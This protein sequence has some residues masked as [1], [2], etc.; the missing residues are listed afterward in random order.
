MTFLLPKDYHS[1]FEFSIGLKEKDIPHYFS[2]QYQKHNSSNSN[3]VRNLKDLFS[4]LENRFQFLIQHYNERY[5]NEYSRIKENEVENKVKK[6]SNWD[7]ESFWY[8]EGVIERPF[9][10]AWHQKQHKRITIKKFNE[11]KSGFEDF[12]E[13][14]VKDDEIEDFQK[15]I[16]SKKI[17][18]KGKPSQL[19]FLILE[20]VGKGWIELPTNSYKK[21]AKYLMELFDVETTHN[22]LENEINP[23]KNSLELD[24]QR[25]VTIKNRKE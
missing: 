17:K 23:N 25:F 7:D 8:F 9:P 24:N 6:I 10:I 16:L 12:I 11:I 20:L 3:F 2:N 21:S 5:L 15:N 18:W 1:I 4:E 19:G 22:N 14:R 13:M